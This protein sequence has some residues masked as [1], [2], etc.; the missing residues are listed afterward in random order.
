[1]AATDTARPPATDPVNEAVRATVEASRRT[2]HSTQEA[3]RYSR[4]LLEQSTEANRKLFAAYTTGMTAGLKATF[5]VHNAALSAGASLLES[6]ASSNR[7]LAKQFT[8]TAQ[9]AQEATLE[10]WQAG[11]RAADKLATSDE[12]A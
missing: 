5:A 1:M 4:D 10:A 2:V 11:V 7:E 3:A 12:K 8:E 6:A 9:Q